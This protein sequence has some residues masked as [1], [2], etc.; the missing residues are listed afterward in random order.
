[1]SHSASPASPGARKTQRNNNNNNNNNNTNNNNN[2]KGMREGQVEVEEEILPLC[3]ICEEVADKICADC[4]DFYCSRSW[5][6]HVDCFAQVHARGNRVNH[7]L[8]S[9]EKAVLILLQKRTNNKD[10]SS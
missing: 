10:N 9:L 1:V 5:M 7:K 3:T 2:S 4:G 6:G 8:E